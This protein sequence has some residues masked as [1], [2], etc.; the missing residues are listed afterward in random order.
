MTPMTRTTRT[1]LR[2]AA[3][4]AAL[5]TGLTGCG[6]GDALDALDEA[7]GEGANISLDATG[8]LRALPRN[9]DIGDVYVGGEPVTAQGADAAELCAKRTDATCDGVTV[10]G[11]K[12]SVVR[13]SSSEDRIDFTLLVFGTQEQATAHVEKMT[14]GWKKPDVEKRRSVKPVSFDSG[15]DTTDAFTYADPA[16]T[17]VYMRVGSVVSAVTGSGVTAE[18]VQT[19]ARMQ[20][21]RIR[22]IAAGHDPKK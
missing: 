15:A 22:T 14:A 19:A 4:A 12:E 18:N 13:G 5:L 21:D 11:L 6:A 9:S 1:G 2:G 17:N 20:A 3:V 8:L 16:G 7:T 10:A